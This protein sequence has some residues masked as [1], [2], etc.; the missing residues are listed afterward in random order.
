MCWRKKNKGV[1][2]VMKW[3]NIFKEDSRIVCFAMLI[4]LLLNSANIA[5]TLLMK[6]MINI[7]NFKQGNWVTYASICAIIIF[8]IYVLDVNYLNLT[9]YLLCKLHNNMKI[10]LY[11]QI[12][13]IKLE[14]INSINSGQI[15]SN[16]TGNM[17]ELCELIFQKI[18]RGIIQLLYC[19][20]VFVILF[21]IDVSLT[22]FLIFFQLCG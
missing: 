17:D 9:D 13:N 19:I 5:L 11:N 10:N 7:E 15:L 3:T 20:I 4:G 18:L 14:K 1:V 8:A 12:N 21:S 2:E 22:L 16:I 6:H